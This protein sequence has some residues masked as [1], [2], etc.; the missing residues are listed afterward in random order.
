MKKIV[1][2]ILI[3]G[4]LTVFAQN[5][6]IK[7]YKIATFVGVRDDK[8][9]SFPNNE[10][11]DFLNYIKQDKEY[12]D[13]LYLGLSSH[14][15]FKHNIE[16]DLR[17]AFMG[18]MSDIYISTQYFPI[19]NV[20]FNIGFYSNGYMLNE[21]STYHKI[22]DIGMF[23]DLETNYRQRFPVDIGFF[24]GLNLQIRFWKIHTLMK[25]NTGMSSIKPFSETV[26]QKEVNGNY[27]K[28]I[29]YE[30]KHNFQIYYFPELEFNIDCI[31]IQNS[32]IGFQLQTSYF[33]ARKSIDYKRTIYEWTNQNPII[34]NI[35]GQKHQIRLF[36]LDLGL[37][38]RLN[39]RND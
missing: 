35:S 17:F 25:L 7:S 3:I 21:F 18:G 8:R 14:I 9:D 34:E 32:T 2:F 39:N 1:I 31:K 20:G 10:N 16:T 13:Y 28:N 6:F 38:V 12:V 36:Y 24:G 23:G 26:G 15:L 22:N 30:T 4:N 37:Y 29:E 19:K 11:L 5:G 33:Y 27:R